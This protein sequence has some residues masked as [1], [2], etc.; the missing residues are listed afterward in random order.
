MS[1]SEY[2]LHPDFKDEA[3]ED[4]FGILTY[5]LKKKIQIAAY[6][7]DEE[8]TKIE[9]KEIGEDLLNYIYENLNDE[10]ENVIVDQL[11]PAIAQFMISVVPRTAGYHA[12]AFMMEVPAVRDALIKFGLANQ[13]LMK[14][15]EQHK[16]K[17]VTETTPMSEAKVEEILARNK[18][19][20]EALARAMEST[21]GLRGAEDDDDDFGN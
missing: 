5:M 11:Y 19:H 15:L 17:I 13:L 12:S 6:L 16:L 1:N 2:L 18:A 9:F 4:V 14:Y 21:S 20:E 3:P 10:E 7:E 8:G